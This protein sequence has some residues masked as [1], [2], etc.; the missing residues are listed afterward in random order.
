ML[1]L[2]S[3]TPE[4]MDMAEGQS[5]LAPPST[6]I[7]A[8]L[9]EVQEELNA[10]VEASKG[11]LEGKAPSFDVDELVVRVEQWAG[12]A[13]LCSTDASRRERRKA[14]VKTAAL[15]LLALFEMDRQ[16]SKEPDDLVITGMD[17]PW[18]T[19]AP[20][21]STSPGE[22][23]KVFR[24]K[25]FPDAFPRRGAMMPIEVVVRPT[26]GTA[27]F[28]YEQSKQA[29]ADAELEE[30]EWVVKETKCR[31]CSGELD[32]HDPICAIVQP[33][34]EAGVTP[35]QLYRV[36]YGVKM[37]KEPEAREADIPSELYGVR[38][39]PLE[40]VKVTQ[41]PDE[42]SRVHVQMSGPF[43]DAD[44][45]RKFLEAGEQVSDRSD[46]E[47]ERCFNGNHPR[48]EHGVCKLD[49]GES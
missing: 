18:K 17:E 28:L 4:S 16:A 24:G 34:A 47:P 49:G 22:A 48:D 13:D 38:L 12:T 21:K 20:G 23:W 40:A 41:D 14:L 3:K 1:S 25:V 5:V 44:A 46:T 19:R 31:H 33:A 6:A 37:S 11:T 15:S 26:R 42:P 30:S 8:L 10:Y 7:L 39:G 36:L 43:L 35:L 2:M 32:E 45:M 29:Q 9:V 27:D